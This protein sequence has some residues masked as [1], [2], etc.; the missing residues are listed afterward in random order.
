[1]PTHLKRCIKCK[2]YT[3]TEDLCANCGTNLENVYPPRFSLQDKYQNYR[4]EYFREK[5]L[6]KFPDLNQSQT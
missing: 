2:Q 4:I 5:M 6:K 1:M 3:I